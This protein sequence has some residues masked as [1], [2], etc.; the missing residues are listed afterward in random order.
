MKCAHPDQL[1]LQQSNDP[2]QPWHAGDRRY[3]HRDNDCALFFWA[4]RL[5]CPAASP[6][7]L[8]TIHERTRNNP[9]PHSEQIISKGL[10]RQSPNAPSGSDRISPVRDR[11]LQEAV[12]RPSSEPDPFNGKRYSCPT[13]L[14]RVIRTPTSNDV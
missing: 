8:L 2:I 14:L 1:R 13:P 4:S 3:R 5:T 12:G 11:L 7:D 9:A 10:I 6:W